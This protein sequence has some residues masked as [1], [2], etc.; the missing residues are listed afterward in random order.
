MLVDDHELVRA[1]IKRLLSDLPD[2]NV[3]AEAASGEDAIVKAKQYCPDVILMDI[4]MPGIGGL[5]AASRIIS[6]DGRVAVIGL[7]SLNDDLHVAKLLR[8]G[9]KGYLT[10]KAE[11]PE[12]AEAL[13]KVLAGEIFISQEIANNLA[14]S[15]AV[16]NLHDSPFSQL[17]KRE[18][19]ITQMITS[20]HR[21]NEIAGILSLSPKTVNAHKYR[22]FEKVGVTNDVELTLYAVKYHLIEPSELI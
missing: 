8:I 10:K 9:A 11:A 17:T 6:R 14:A 13:D 15:L 22:I 1:G 16:N 20:G 21:A 4:R 5:E 3:I 19:Q 12:M 18:L 2:V 7:S